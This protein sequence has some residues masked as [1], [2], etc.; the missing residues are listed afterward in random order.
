MP[1][2][3]IVKGHPTGVRVPYHPMPVGIGE[4]MRLVHGIDRGCQVPVVVVLIADEPMNVAV[5]IDQRQRG[6]QVRTADLAARLGLTLDHAP[7]CFFALP[8][9]QPR[10][11][12]VRSALEYP[13]IAVEIGHPVDRQRERSTFRECRH[14]MLPV[15]RQRE[16]ILDA[17]ARTKYQQAASAI[18]HMTISPVVHP[19]GPACI[20]GHDLKGRRLI[21]EIGRY[22]TVPACCINST[23]ISAGVC[24]PQPTVPHRLS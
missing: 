16:F 2:M 22:P 19:S 13:C 24:Q 6:K 12:A 4:S 8:L 10:Q 9:G 3:A 17:N 15:C 11:G 14:S 23:R 20:S 18:E 1:S 7:A 5:G 21:G